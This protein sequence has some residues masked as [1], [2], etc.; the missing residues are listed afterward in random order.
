MPKVGVHLT[1]RER[2]EERMNCV[3]CRTLVTEDEAIPSFFAGE[4]EY[5]EAVCFGCVD[6]HLQRASDDEFELKAN[7]R[8]PDHAR[9]LGR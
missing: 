1:D 3:F 5:G 6:E 2:K 7:H 4:V 8:L 9:P